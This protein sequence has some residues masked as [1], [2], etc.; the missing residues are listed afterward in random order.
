MT[1]PARTRLVALVGA[2]TSDRRRAHTAGHPLAVVTSAETG[3]GVP[4]LRAEIA[5]LAEPAPG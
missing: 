3:L 2:L 5:A 4:E 1:Q